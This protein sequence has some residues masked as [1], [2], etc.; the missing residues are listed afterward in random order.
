MN[1]RLLFTTLLAF[2]LPEAALAQVY[3]VPRRANR[4]PVHTYEFEWRHLDILVGPEAEGVAAP[5]AHRAHMQPPGAPGGP[6]PTAPSTGPQMR[7]PGVP[8]ADATKGPPKSGKPG[9]EG[10][11]GSPVESIEPGSPTPVRGNRP[12]GGTPSEPVAT[13]SDLYV[14]IALSA[15]GG[16]P[17]GGPA[18]ATS[19][20]T[21]SGGVRFYF[22]ESERN[23]AQYAAPQLEDT[24]RY[25]VDR[26]KFV[27]TQTFPYILYSSYQEFLQT[28]IA[29]VAEGT[30]GVTST[31]GNLELTL[32]Y[33]GD[34]RLFGEISSHEMAHQFTIQ[35]VRFLADQA[36][37]SGDPLNSIPL[38]FIE[39][40]AEFY[41]KGGLDPEGEM[42]VRDLLINPDLLRGYAFLDFWSPGPYGF[43]WIYKVGQARCQF[44]EETYGAGFIQKVLDNSPKLIS[45]TALAPNMPFE[46]L[47]EM[48]T[49][50]DPQKVATKFE[51]WLKQ[52]A[53][54][55][56]LKAEQTTPSMEVLR[57]R[58]GIVTSLNSSPDGR[59]L[60]Y[61]S[62]IPETGQSQLI[63]L[64]PR[65]PE[66]SVKV[67][68][69]GVPGYESLHPIFGRNF[70]LTDDKLVFVAESM[71]RDT[72]YVQ[73]FKH[74]A[75]PV[76]LGGT[77]PAMG[78]SPYVTNPSGLRKESPYKVRFELGERT[79][80]KLADH[81]LIAA[82]SPAFSPDGKQLAF[83]GLS[84]AGTRDVY[85]LPLD[86]GLDVE[87]QQITHDVYAE[88]SLTWGQAGIVYA[89]DA[90]SHGYYNLF[91]V[92]PESP[93]Q[94]ERLTTEARDHADPTV[95]PDG[96]LFFVAYEKS[97]S[98]LHEYTGG[99]GIVRRT[100]VSTGLF[101]PS[102]APDGNLWLLYHLSGERK[103]A[104]LR[105]QQLMSLEVAQAGKAEAGPPSP[106]PQRSLVGAEPYRPFARENI[107]LGPILGFAGA[108]G[109]GFYGQ[110][111]ASA[112]DRLR[113]HAMLLQVAVYGSFELT[114]GYLLYLNQSR[115]TTYGLG[116]FQSL[117][118][119]VDRTLSQYSDRLPYYALVAGERFFGATGLAR[120][121]LST[122]TFLEANLSI[123]GASYFLDPATS[124]FLNLQEVNGIG[125]LYS[126]WVA[127]KPGTRFQTEGSLAFGYNT[128]RY[129]YTGVP[130]SGSSFLSEVSAGVQPFHGEFYGSLRLDAE[131]YFPI[132]LGSTHLMLRGGA[133]TSFGGRFSQSFYLSSFDTLRGVPF[134][135][136]RWLLGQHYL[137]ST[138]ELRV[139]LD[140]LIRIAF[141]NS[142][143]GVAGFDVGGVGS[144]ARDLWN[145]RV[146]D[147][148]V[149]INVGL[150][151]ILLRL[152]FAYP[153]DIRAPAGRPSNKWVT[154]FSIGLAGLEGYLFKGHG[155]SSPKKKAPAPP[156]TLGGAHVGPM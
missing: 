125:D 30:L 3:V 58:K 78:R 136:E 95:L 31:Q 1:R 57:E 139:P 113:N 152:H 21:K 64:D 48:L 28:N 60:I 38:W 43:L 97:R 8:T 76:S 40:L 32:P 9:E 37:V 13:G 122:F 80:Y 115:R 93:S 79:A 99:G 52:R 62:I 7:S 68:G 51:A 121:P 96:R 29:A 18:Y 135:D 134:G 15:D 17:D 131:R 34:H 103:P 114:D 148:A 153:F 53:Y 33:L 45:G 66:D 26:F 67:Q 107:D 24:Y 140:A 14:P 70:A 84:E 98:D 105:S 42:M 112:S 154:Q 91:R 22:Y 149:G 94:V 129:H 82:Y 130:I 69:D 145:H 50:D 147:A 36:K 142:L 25:L 146:L 39:G 111:F 102:P 151:P 46:G 124:F 35:K 4:A 100:D 16:T 63:M 117:R 144:S 77:L 81:G 87:P 2:V 65:A 71:A 143:M 85:V 109:G 137:Y 54:S 27:P 19:L 110:V 10:T 20:G 88:R 118:F 116:L 86:K 156:V 90:T 44:M 23:V 6:S 89:S 108:G 120:Y 92:K 138:L 75:E 106:L 141:L 128:L 56:Y 155:K 127:N 83:I 150:G 123:G 12:D 132:P 101:E 47:I 74:T 104:L 133:G 72:L 119:R 126:E 73:A 49:G 55:T 61:R 59:V 11:G 5:P 41:A